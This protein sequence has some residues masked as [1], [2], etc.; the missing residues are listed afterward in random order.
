MIRRFRPVVL[1]LLTAVAVSLPASPRAGPSAQTSAPRAPKLV[2][3]VVVD[4]MRADYLETYSSALSHGLRTLMKEGAW[5]QRAAYPYLNTITCAG[6]STI[7]T[8]ALPYRHGM[9]LNAWFDRAANRS[10]ECTGDPATTKVSYG[11]LTGTSDSPAALL[12]PTLAEQIRD[13]AGARAIAISLK[14][15]SAI[16]LAGHKAD[17]V[18]WFDD[19]GAWTTSSAFAKSPPAVFQRFID[20]HPLAAEVGKTW[21]RTLDPSAY[22]LTDDGVGERPPSG[23]TRTFPHPLGTPGGKVDSAFLGQWQRSPFAD[24][25]LERMAEAAIDGEKLGSGSATDYLGV[26]LSSL[27]YVGHAF[28]PYSHEV[29]DMLVRLDRTTARLLAHLDARVGRGNYV[30]A[31][32]SDHGVAP[33]PEQIPGA[34]RQLSREVGAAIDGALGPIFGP[35]KYM[36]FSAYTDI[37]LAPGVLDRLKADAKA[38]AAVLAAVGALPGIAHAFRSDEISDPEVRTDPDPVRRAAALGYHP[39]RSG[40]LIIVPREHWILSSSAT[41]HGTLYPYDQR[42]PVIFFGAGVKPGEYT[43]DVT[44]ADV[45]PTLAALA[46]VAFKKL[47]GQVLTAAVA[48]RAGS[49]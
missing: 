24:E 39:A 25:Y 9:V 32:T 30:L 49:K 41:T 5:F 19:R 28:G 11:G 46:H 36:A 16:G 34:G 23:W 40:D 48:P 7:G 29:Q 37:Y 10:R 17:A 15:R 44:P 14:A 20:E 4:Q 13:H 38:S 18:V 21:E 26:S 8:G 43:G 22:K 42:V 1:F 35:G 31:L 47:D 6:H 2:V 3:M 27:D 45:A 12:V 33:I